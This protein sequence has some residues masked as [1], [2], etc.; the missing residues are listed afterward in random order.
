MKSGLRTI[1]AAVALTFAADGLMA[2]KVTLNP[3]AGSPG[4]TNESFDKLV[5][6]KPET[7]WCVGSF[8]EAY[9]VLKASEAV[10]PSS[11]YLIT[12]GDT[13]KFPGRNWKTW[14]IYGANFASD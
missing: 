14:R 9:I 13:G 4:F 8:T 11:Y 7:K 3:V 2:Q 10:V 12:G 5:D 6:G 1:V